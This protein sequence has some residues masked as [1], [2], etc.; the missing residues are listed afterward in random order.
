[1]TLM[2]DPAHPGEVLREFLPEGMTV[3]EVAER[4]HVSRVQ[5]SRLLNCRSSIS[6]EMAIRVAALTGTTAE[7]WLENQMHW[8]LW[9]AVQRPRPPIEPLSTA[10]E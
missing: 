10:N 9:Q 1:M 8:D 7:S 5:L 3:G 6:A 2:H 4:L